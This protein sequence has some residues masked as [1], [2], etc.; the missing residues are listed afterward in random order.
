[1]MS[2]GREG[3]ASPP[4]QP[5]AAYLWL[6]L[7]LLGA[8]TIG[9]PYLG[10]AI[11]FGVDV[12]GRVEIVDHVVPGSLVLITGTWLFVRGRGGRRRG[13]RT[14]LIGAGVTFLAGFWVLAT[15]VPLLADAAR[16]TE[17]WGAALWHAST[18]LPILALSLWLILRTPDRRRA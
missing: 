10:H 2:T 17:T 12:A 5:S 1:M 4:G 3:A 13:A 16:G 8:W 11:G 7:A 18:S 15:H 14:T 6:L 9:V